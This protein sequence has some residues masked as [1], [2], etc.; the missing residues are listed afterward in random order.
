MSY[1][2]I[3]SREGMPFGGMPTD[4]LLYK[5]E[6]TD[7]RLVAAAGRRDASRGPADAYDGYVRGE[8]IDWTPD[9]AWL[10]SDHQRR[11][12]A[13]S[14]LV[15]NNHFNGT[16]GFRPE[17]PRHPELFVGFTGSD[18]RGATNDPRF[19]RARGFVAAHAAD[20]TAR[21]GN[22]DDNALAQRPWT[23]QSLSYS[24]KEVFRRE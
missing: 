4:T 6:E 7:P 15:L 3:R 16:R 22:N 2:E 10:E 11:D 8:I 9:A 13:V 19:D 21:M 5:L 17:L 20:F 12:P 1:T 23:G 14:R 18:P 24:M